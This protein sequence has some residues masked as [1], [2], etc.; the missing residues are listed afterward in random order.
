[1]IA[2]GV[3]AALALV[4]ALGLAYG[5]PDGGAGDWGNTATVAVG[6]GGVCFTW[7]TARQGREHAETVLGLQ[8]NHERLLASEARDQQRLETAYV[9]L[10]E[11]AEAAGQ[12]VQLVLPMLDTNPPR[13]DPP[14]PSLEAQ[15]HIQA[16][17][18]AFG[19]PK[20]LERR[21]SWEAV[22]RKTISTVTVARMKDVPREAFKARR[23]LDEELRSEERSARRALAEQI[24]AELRP[25]RQLES[26]AG[27]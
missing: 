22:V 19:S 1:V 8:L 2:G 21:E 5:A 14:L 6:V 25:R 9:D 26:G 3:L 18:R 13:P 10:L 16:V 24:S 17:V 7:L 20:V 12:W 4:F 27:N 15:G 11:M 23:A